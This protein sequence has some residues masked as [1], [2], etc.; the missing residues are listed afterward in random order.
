MPCNLVEEQVKT[1]SS[2]LKME[3]AGSSKTLIMINRIHG[4]TTKMTVNS[5]PAWFAE[6][7]VK[8]TSSPNTMPSR[9]RE[10]EASSTCS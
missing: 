3:A 4:I 5:F 1:H 2:N 7:K 9:C 6:S 10:G 8:V